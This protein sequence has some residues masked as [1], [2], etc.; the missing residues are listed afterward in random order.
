MT[1]AVPR[2]Q[3]GLT[4]FTSGFMSLSKQLESELQWS[5]WVTTFEESPRWLLRLYLDVLPKE[6]L[7]T[8]NAALAEGLD[9]QRMGSLHQ[10]SYVTH[11][12]WV[13]KLCGLYWPQRQAKKLLMKTWDIWNKA[14]HCSE[15]MRYSV[16]QG[17]GELQLST[18]ILWLVANCVLL[19]F[20]CFL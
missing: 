3:S 8:S 5:K 13:L 14:S 20:A 18:G 6:T 4:L 15:C 16:I 9:K 17:F 19:R 1:D 12:V 7:N 11:G 10:S 2:Q